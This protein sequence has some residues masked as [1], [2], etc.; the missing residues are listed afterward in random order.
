MKSLINKVAVLAG[1]NGGIGSAVALSLAQE[2]CNLVLLARNGEQLQQTADE[3]KSLTDCK[4]LVC[5]TDLSSFA[6]VQQT[7]ARIQRVFKRVDILYNGV[8]GRLEDSIFEANPE[9]IGYF[10]QSTLTGTIWLTQG[11]LPLMPGSEAHIVNMITDWAMPNT[12]GPS[13]FVAGKYGLLGFGQAL[14]KEALP[15]GVRVTNILPGDV[16]SN[17]P[18]QKNTEEVVETYGVSKIPL[19]DIVNVILLCLKLEL[20]KID[21]LVLTPVD[22]E[23]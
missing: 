5:P 15:R 2:G 6:A 12:S 21:Q 20:A 8:A 13:T 16:A 11:L 10:I 18:L 22:P 23:Y 3:I 14:S 7:I 4:V 19:S 17:L 1:A 9:E